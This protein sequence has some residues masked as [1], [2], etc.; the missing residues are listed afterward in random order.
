MWICPKVFSDVRG[1]ARERCKEGARV[2][3]A[4]TNSKGKESGEVLAAVSE[5]CKREVTGA[6]KKKGKDQ[7]CYAREVLQ[8]ERKSWGH[9]EITEGAVV[10]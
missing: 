2:C 4:E 8:W 6:L 9:W 3:D 7:L 5:Y 1:Q 10:A